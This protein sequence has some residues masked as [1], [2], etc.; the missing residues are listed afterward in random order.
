MIN[1]NVNTEAFENNRLSSVKDP[2]PFENM[3]HSSPV[4]LKGNSFQGHLYPVQ[5]MGE[6]V[7]ALR[8]LPQDESSINSDHAMYA[9]NFIDP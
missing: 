8:S 6:A 7:Q 5:T 1:S 4:T 2:I 3:L 9:Y